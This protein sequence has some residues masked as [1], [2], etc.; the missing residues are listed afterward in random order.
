MA[1]SVRVE[2]AM[3]EAGSSCKLSFGQYDKEWHDHLEVTRDNETF[4]EDA[5]DASRLNLSLAVYEV[6][7]E[8]E[9]LDEHGHCDELRCPCGSTHMAENAHTCKVRVH[10]IVR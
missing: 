9:G 4:L 3:K 5:R 10:G 8:P 6:H 7:A 2:N 1:E